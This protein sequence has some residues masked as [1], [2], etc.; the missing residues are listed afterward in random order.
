M[1]AASGGEEALEPVCTVEVT[2]YKVG[3][4]DTIQRYFENT[5]A[6]GGDNIVKFDLFNTDG[7]IFITFASEKV[8][9]RV[10]SHRQHK[11][12]DQTLKVKLY[13]P[14]QIRPTYDDRVLFARFARNI[15]HHGLTNFFKKLGLTPANFLFGEEEDK[16]LIIFDEKIDFQKL[17]EACKKRALEG[18]HLQPSKVHVSNCILVLNLKISTTEDTIELYF[19]NEKRSKGGPVEKIEFH[20]DKEYCL[21]YFED[22][23]ICE[24]VLQ[25][26]HK[27]DGSELQVSLYYECLG[28]ISNDTGPCFKPPKPVKLE[29]LEFAK[30]QFLMKSEPNRAA[31]QKKLQ[32]CFTQIHWPQAEADCTTL[33]CTLTSDVQDC[34]KIALTWAKQAEQNLYDFLKVISV[35]ELRV[36]QEFFETVLQIFQNLDIANPG[37]VFLLVKKEEFS[38]QVVVHNDMAK[39]VRDIEGII[40]KAEAE[41]VRKQKQTKVSV[42]DLKYHELKLLLAQKYCSKM[43]QQFHGL[44]VNIN[45]NKNEIVFEGLMED[46]RTAQVAMYEVVH[47]AAVSKFKNI[48]EGRLF[49][50]KSK[51]V[52]DYIVAK[53]KSEKL[54]AVWEVVGTKLHIYADSDEAIIQST[55]IINGSVKE[56]QRDLESNQKCV[57]QSQKWND[58]MKDLDKQHQG[59]LNIILAQDFS[60]LFLYFTDDILS[61]VIEEVNDFL[62]RNCIF[63]ELVTCKSGTI[64]LIERRNRDEIDKI[65]KD[66]THSYVQITIKSKEG[67]LIQGTQDGISQATYRMQELIDEVQHC[68]HELHKPGIVEYMEGKGREHITTVENQILCVIQLRGQ[69]QYGL[70]KNEIETDS[71]G[72]VN[73]REPG[74]VIQAECSSYGREKIFTALGDITEIDADV[75][76]NA[77]D[78]EL[79]HSG[80]LAKAIVDKGG[81]VIREECRQHV[82]MNGHLAEGGIHVTSAG[83]LRAKAIIHAVSP[84]WKGGHNKEEEV[85]R[86]TIFNCLLIAVQRSFKSIAIPALG[87]ETTEYPVIQTTLVITDA[88][89][90]F[91]KTYEDFFQ[92]NQE[93]AIHEV[94]LCGMEPQTV[95]CFTEALKNSFGTQSVREVRQKPTSLQRSLKTSLPGEVAV[96]PSIPMNTKCDESSG[97]GNISIKVVKGEMANQK[98]DVIVNTVAKSLDLTHGA[99]SQSLLKQ[100]GQSLQDEC[101]KK[102]PNGI[103]D[104]DIA[105]TGGG[106]LDCKIVCHVALRPWSDGT[107]SKRILNE[108]MKKCLDQCE[109]KGFKSI[110]FPALGTGNLKYPRDFVAKEMFHLISTYSRDNPSSSVTDVR[111]V[112]YQRDLPT[113]EAF[114]SEQQMWSSNRTRAGTQM[115]RHNLPQKT[116]EN[117]TDSIPA[118]AEAKDTDDPS[119][120]AD[121]FTFGKIDVK[122]YQGDITQDD[123]DCIVNISNVAL[124]LLQN[125]VSKALMK[126]GGKPFADEC[127]ARVHDMKQGGIA[128][129][130]GHGLNCKYVIHVVAV[131]SAQ[132]TEVINKC[133]LKAEELKANSIAFPSFGKGLDVSTKKVANAMFKA[134][135]DFQ[136]TGAKTVTEVCIVIH[137]SQMVQVFVDAAR[138]L[139]S[140]AKPKTFWEKI[141]S[142]FTGGSA[143]QVS[144]KVPLQFPQVMPPHDQIP[145]VWIDVFA[146][147]KQSLDAAIDKLNYL[148]KNDFNK[149]DFNEAVIKNFSPD[150]ISELQKLAKPW[151]L[152]LTVD[153]KIGRITIEGVTD[154]V[155][156]VSDGIHKLIREADKKEQDKRSADLL[157]KLVQWHYIEITVESSELREYPADVNLLIENAYKD[158]KAFVTFFTSDKEEYKIDFSKMEEFP[159]KDVNDT[160]TVVRKDLIQEMTVSECPSTWAK[161]APSENLKVVNLQSTDKEYQNVQKEFLQSVGGLRTIIKLERIQNRTLYQQYEAKKKLI[162]QNN[163]G[164]QNESSLWHGTSADTVDSISMHGFNRSYCGKNAT[165]YGDGVYFAKNASYSASDIYSRPD[166]CGN[167]RI[168]FC[169]VLTGKYTTGKQGMRVPP[170]KSLSSLNVLYDSV[171]NNMTNPEIFVIFSDTQ[172]IP[173]YLIT[174]K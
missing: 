160:V 8:A 29:R 120:F 37:G 109:K 93:S 83:N 102:Y 10:A 3:L 24:R 156:K 39:F 66:L 145:T 108:M 63:E 4:E 132:W 57:I 33:T 84:A 59:K 44:K 41:F 131:N 153:F 61:K 111:F 68:E 15:D 75:L 134:I 116:S 142:T 36:C 130:K 87:S 53:L 40:K 166:P 158:Q 104:G 140:E 51:E 6:S 26:K 105:V 123:A 69:E 101:K 47:C 50:Y 5:E 43:E 128:V 119:R 139:D 137:Q 38:F 173:E 161:M 76:V 52:N 95:R 146:R 98:V 135:I 56:H 81:R 97:F 168:Y 27:I 80:V 62:S 169:R 136:A 155:M 125:A 151:G 19:E 114:E 54:I 162:E 172:A 46:I 100:G 79:E 13:I 67:F 88:V 129:T 152:Q 25:H 110:A 2:G 74:P 157:K 49:L 22:H 91:F 1:K 48:P 127:R 167:K 149:T 121:I 86:E 94:Y 159:V 32:D 34:E 150:Q 89:R 154:G 17:K 124:D 147:E 65:A 14:P 171:V 117:S 12:E 78:L 170:P 90:D 174:F 148:V 144:R 106:K 58:K 23:N 103:R 73:I 165:A 143:K 42:S 30:M 112:V 164:H 82:K 28:H 122:I 20:R 72:F 118:T 71:F 126:K 70:E 77:T 35:H 115:R 21:V 7:I 16:V 11:V 163:P 9:Q 55:S 92:E 107:T 45:L 18:S 31:L 64:K 133:L 85:L 99:V 138:N 141:T 60:K 113:I 96:M